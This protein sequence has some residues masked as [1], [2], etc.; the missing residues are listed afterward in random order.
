MPIFDGTGDLDTFFTKF[1]ILVTACDWTEKETICIFLN[2]CLWGKAESIILSFPSDSVLIYHDVKYKMYVWFGSMR[3]EYH[4]QKQLSEITRKPVES[5][6]EFCARAAILDNKAYPLSPTER[7]KYGVEAI[8]KGC[9][10]ESVQLVAIANGWNGRTIDETVNWIMDL[11]NRYHSY[12]FYKHQL[13]RRSMNVRDSCDRVPYRA[14]AW[15]PWLWSAPACKLWAKNL[16]TCLRN[17][18]V[19][20]VHSLPAPRLIDAVIQDLIAI[21]VNKAQ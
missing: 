8:I 4:Y 5:I 1:E 2:D 20:N 17:A 6:Q 3:D 9:N 19:T 14:L 13:N 21:V 10:L 7:E 16:I 11:E 15:I 18:T 12:N